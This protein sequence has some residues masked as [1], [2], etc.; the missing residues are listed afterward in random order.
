VSLIRSVL[1]VVVMGWWRLGGLLHALVGAAVADG[2]EL[3]ATV[4][5]GEP[6]GA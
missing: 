1:A 3:G 2:I 4:A 5:V 6:V